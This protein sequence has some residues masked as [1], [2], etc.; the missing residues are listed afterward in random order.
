MIRIIIHPK[1]ND[2]LVSD[3]NEYK[4]NHINFIQKLLKVHSNSKKP[5][6]EG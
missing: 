3:L 1:I 4:N 5:W 2:N 6:P